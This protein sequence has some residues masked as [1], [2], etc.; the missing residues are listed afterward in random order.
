MLTVSTISH[1][2][3]FA[4]FALEPGSNSRYRETLWAED[5]GAL[6]QLPVATETAAR[7]WGRLFDHVGV[8]P[9]ELGRAAQLF[10][11]AARAGESGHHP[12]AGGRSHH[13]QAQDLPRGIEPTDRP[14]VQELGDGA[15]PGTVD[16]H[17]PLSPQ[18]PVRGGVIGNER[19]RLDRAIEDD[20]ALLW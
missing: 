6:R 2:L 15:L 10:G 20:L 17:V 13:A 7:F 5:N 11:W 9:A 8:D 16:E 19:L 3:L 1:P 4:P 14:A 12:Q 18:T